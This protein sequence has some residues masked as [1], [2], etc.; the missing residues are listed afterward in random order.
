[1]PAL[2]DT[3]EPDDMSGGFRWIIPNW[4]KIRSNK[5]RSERFVVGGFSWQLLVFPQGNSCDHLSVYLDV[6]EPDSLPLGWA[7]YAQFSLAVECQN[8]ETK[9]LK[10]ETNH[11]FEGRECDWGFTQ[12]APLSDITD[13]SMAIWSTTPSSSRAN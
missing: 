4:S 7:Q 6:A 5:H 12:F 9:H 1:M 13:P 8:D 11:T 10:K 2:E 3:S